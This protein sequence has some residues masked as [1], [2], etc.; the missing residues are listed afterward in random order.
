MSRIGEEVK[1]D[2]VI[3]KDVLVD[4]EDYDEAVRV[5]SEMI[6]MSEEYIMDYDVV[7]E[8]Y[9]EDDSE[10]FTTWYHSDGTKV[11][12]GDPIGFA[13][14]LHGVETNIFPYKGL[15]EVDE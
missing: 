11:A 1:L 10:E 9:A 13:I 12:P 6:E 3:N 7:L 15:K 8:Y 2:K 5:V 4:I 14:N